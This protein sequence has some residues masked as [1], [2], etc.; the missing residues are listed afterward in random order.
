ME[1][2]DKIKKELQPDLTV[3]KQVNDFVSNINKEIKKSKVKAVCVTGGSVAKATFLKGDFDVDLFV[4]FDYSYKEKNISKLLE[5][6]LAKFK[7]ELVHGSRDYFQIKNKLNYEIVPVLDVK[8]PEL[9]VNVT[10]MSPLHVDWVNKK[11]KK[12]QDDEIRLTKKFCKVIKVYGA[13]SYINGFSGHV[14]DILIIY[15]GSFLNLLKESQKWKPQVVIDIEKYYDSK[16]DIL[17][18][19]N[20]SKITGPMIV[21]DPI[22]KA[23]NAASALSYEKFTIFKKKAK[24]VLKKPSEKFFIEE[25]IGVTLLKKKYKKNLFIVTLKAMSGKKDVIGSKIV[26]AYKFTKTELQKVGFDFSKSGW[27]WNDKYRVLYWFVFKN[28]E[29]PETRII[30]GPPLDKKD[31]VKIFKNKYKKGYEK[32]GK[33]FAEVKVKLRTADKNILE[34]SKKDYF[35]EKIK[36]IKTEKYI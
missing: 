32:K 13:E 21:I 7:P 34:I 18:N 5:R 2:L 31:H 24:E 3:I 29:L 22:L 33:L 8:N 6:I 26:K 27:T 12:G 15:Y 11:I 10:D 16:R 23:R 17:F 35:K 28:M 36:L 25:K 20:Q 14:V 9:A 19:M 1:F 4:R 30:E